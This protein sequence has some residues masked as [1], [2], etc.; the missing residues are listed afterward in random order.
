MNRTLVD[1][2]IFL[3]L[4]TNDRDWQGWSI[5]QLTAAGMSSRL[6]VVDVI[7]AELT[8]RFLEREAGGWIAG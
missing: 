5:G 7:Y 8:I 2:N 1:T 4:I 3:D 6:V